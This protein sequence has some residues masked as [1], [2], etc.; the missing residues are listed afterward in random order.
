MSIVGA[1]KKRFM[2]EAEPGFDKRIY[3]DLGKV[4]L[5][6]NFVKA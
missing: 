1:K 3:P 2:L 6:I 4:K 5:K